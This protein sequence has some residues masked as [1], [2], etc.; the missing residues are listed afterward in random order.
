MRRC[1]LLLSETRLL[2]LPKEQRLAGLL[3]A[4][5]KY[6]NVVS[7]RL[8]EQVLHGLHE[9]LRG[10]QSAHEKSRGKLLAHELEQDPDNVYRALLTVVLR[11]VFLLYA[12]ERGMLSDDATFAD[13]Y[14]IGGLYE[15][16]REDAGL[17]PDTMDD[18]YGAWAQ[19]LVLFRMVHDGAKSGGMRLPTR[20]GELFS[21]SRFPFLEGWHGS[22][23]PQVTQ[24]IKAPL[25]PDGDGLPGA[26]QVAGAWTASVSRTGRST[27]SRSD[28]CTRR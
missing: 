24:A 3:E 13:H 7:E 2:A 14:S 8:S 20:R 10:F 1:S 28:P 21:P 22:G 25:V 19:L 17:Y 12:E 27:W 4:G 18:R 23:A 26:R 5:R 11:L 9:L 16:L 6:Q 15:R